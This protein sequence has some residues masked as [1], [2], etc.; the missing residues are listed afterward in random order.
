MIIDKLGRKVTVNNRRK[1]YLIRY[2]E[3]LGF[4][5]G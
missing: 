2:S 1:S 5:S 3:A 4:D